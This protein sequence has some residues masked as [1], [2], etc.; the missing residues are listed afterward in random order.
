MPKGLRSYQV[1]VQFIDV[2][3]S[4]AAALESMALFGFIDLDS[5]AK[6]RRGQD[7]DPEPQTIRAAFELPNY[8]KVLG[9]R[10]RASV[11]EIKHAY[12]LLALKYHPD[13][14][15]DPAGVQRFIEI[16]EAYDVL[17]DPKRRKSYDR[18]MAA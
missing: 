16:T 17:C 7:P 18:R 6:K 14:N 12:R 11:K 2:S 3:A 4:I 9:V 5:L 10:R 8:Y 15:R 1:G 13:V